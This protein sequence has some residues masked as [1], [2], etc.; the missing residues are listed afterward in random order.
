MALTSQNAPLQPWRTLSSA[1]TYSDRWLTLR[2]DHC[3]TAEG[4]VIAPYHVLEFADWIN[5]LALTRAGDVV[6]VHQYRHGAG[7]CMLGLPSGTVETGETPEAAARRELEEETGYVADR[8][9]PIVD[10]YAN[11]AKQANR[12]FS[13]LAL[14]AEPAG[15]R[16]HDPTEPIELI[17]RPYR[18]FL[19]EVTNGEVELQG[20][21]F[22]A[23]FAGQGPAAD[24]LGGDA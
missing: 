11:P 3:E 2:S 14:D 6:L 15:R 8:F 13:F 1:V 20:L 7:H 19:A 10:C 16:Q 5:V 12:V 18:D 9:V 23:L 24:Y 21:H 4:T 22:A 17:V